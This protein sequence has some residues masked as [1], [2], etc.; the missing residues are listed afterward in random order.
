[1]CKPIESSAVET[2]YHLQATPLDFVLEELCTTPVTSEIRTTY[3][4]S[5]YFYRTSNGGAT[6][7]RL[8]KIAKMDPPLSGMESSQTPTSTT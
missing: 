4:P 8:L 5:P 3:K 6:P 2:D 7:D 1:M